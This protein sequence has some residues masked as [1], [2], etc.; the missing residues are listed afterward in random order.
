MTKI[1]LRAA[2]ASDDRQVV[3]QAISAA[4]EAAPEL[5]ARAKALQTESLNPALTDAQAVKA[6]SD[7]DA[8]RFQAER[9][10]AAL[11]ALQERDAALQAQES[12]AARRERYSDAA[13]AVKDAMARHAASWDAHALALAGLVLEIEKAKGLADAVN[14]D[15]PADALRLTMPAALVEIRTQA[16]RLRTSDA[17]RV[18]GD[19]P[20]D[21]TQPGCVPLEIIKGGKAA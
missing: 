8:A 6:R 7:Y 3:Q 9:M 15:L 2:L 14:A 16:K 11:E 17:L 1:D 18:L 13:A 10:A 12:E 20:S 4:T 5:E 19:W 21:A